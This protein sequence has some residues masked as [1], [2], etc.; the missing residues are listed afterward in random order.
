MADLI[1]RHTPYAV[2][3]TIYRHSLDTTQQVAAHLKKTIP[4]LPIIY[5]GPEL[6]NPYTRNRTDLH[7]D[8]LVLGEGE[9]TFVEVLEELNSERPNFLRVKGL[10][11]AK[12]MHQ[13]Q[14]SSSNPNVRFENV[15]ESNQLFDFTEFREPCKDL[16]SLPLPD[17]SDFRLADYQSVTPIMF[18]RGCPGN[19]SF[20]VEQNCLGRGYRCRSAKNIFSEITHYYSLGRRS[21]YVRDSALN[22]SPK[23]L[24]ELCDLIISSG[25]KIFL[26]GNAQLRRSTIELLPKMRAAGFYKLQYGLESASPSV[27]KDMHKNPDLTTIG[28]LLRATAEAGIGVM[29]Y[30]ILCYP[31]ET[32]AD[33]Q[34]TLDFFQENAGFFDDIYVSICGLIAEDPYRIPQYLHA[35]QSAYGVQWSAANWYNHNVDDEVRRS[36]VRRFYDKAVEIQVSLGKT[37][38]S[39]ESTMNDLD[40]YRR[41]G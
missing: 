2:G 20:C 25:Y 15:Y 27:L 22:G 17:F 11:I 3:F 1:L 24:N 40:H 7:A 6:H 10:G 31:S 37:F 39:L 21:F 26:T 33:F 38:P 13:N 41:E 32:E 34:Q 36:R 14:S 16:D 5:G 4:T 8:L 18:S 9:D 35:H 19:C 30:F 29:L 23:M 28:R 12:R